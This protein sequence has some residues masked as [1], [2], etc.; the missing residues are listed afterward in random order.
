MMFGISCAQWSPRSAKHPLLGEQVQ[1]PTEADPGPSST[2]APRCTVLL[3]WSP[4][5]ATCKVWLSLLDRLQRQAGSTSVVGIAAHGTREDL[6]RVL[7]D[8]G[9]R[10]PQIHD[11]DG[12]WLRKLKVEAIPRLLVI[13][14]SAQLIYASP[15]DADTAVVEGVFWHTAART[16][17]WR[18]CAR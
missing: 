3:L 14:S 4:W 7:Q 10:I 16:P 6:D 9:I 11:P 15:D 17:A 2:P 18:G 1:R 13:D 5:C 12:A 8:Y